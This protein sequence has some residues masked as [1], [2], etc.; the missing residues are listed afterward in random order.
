MTTP[1]A[2]YPNRVFNIDATLLDIHPKPAPV[3]VVQA[4]PARAQ[5][6]KSTEIHP[7]PPAPSRKRTHATAT[8]AAVPAAKVVP[9]A[10]PKATPQPVVIAKRIKIMP[11]DDEIRRSHQK[12]MDRLDGSMSDADFRELD[13]TWVSDY[14]LLDAKGQPLVPMSHHG[15]AL[16]KLC[17]SKG[18]RI[19]GILAENKKDRKYVHQPNDGT[20]RQEDGGTARVVFIGKANRFTDKEQSKWAMLPCD[21]VIQN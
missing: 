14:G 11:S 15:H 1:K 19:L 3:P 9:V 21:T 13:G 10:P 20:V 8:T 17:A 5:P 16:I 6:L 7:K 12:Y 4:P 18:I 2:V